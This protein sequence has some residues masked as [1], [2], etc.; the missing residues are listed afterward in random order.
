MPGYDGTG[1]RGMGSMTGGGRGFCA[2]PLGRTAGNVPAGGF[3]RRGVGRGRGWRNRYYA[4][5]MPLWQRD[6]Y[7]YPAY[8][9][10][11]YS[12]SG[13]TI[14]E[15]KEMLRAEAEA[16]KRDLEDVQNRIGILEKNQK[17]T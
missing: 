11:G 10:G 17:E 6:G 3:F 5:G 1:P 12:S 8:G 15:E 7:E 14:D 2:V 9:R 16:L 13:P 4:T